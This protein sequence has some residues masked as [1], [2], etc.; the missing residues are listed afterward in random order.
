MCW[1]GA[2]GRAARAWHVD[3]RGQA[4][5]LLLVAIDLRLDHRR[6]LLERRDVHLLGGKLLLLHGIG[7]AL[8]VRRLIVT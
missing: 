3:A 4:R 2:A 7:L 5:E 8:V 1:A 6:G